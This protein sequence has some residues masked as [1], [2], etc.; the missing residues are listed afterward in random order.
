MRNRVW[1][2]ELCARAR[3]GCRRHPDRSFGFINARDGWAE[4]NQPAQRLDLFE[5][6]GS[7]SSA[8]GPVGATPARCHPSRPAS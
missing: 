1:L 5:R 8:I 3:N 6:Q 7:P 4:R 2:H